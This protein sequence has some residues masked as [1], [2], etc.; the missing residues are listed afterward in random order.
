MVL[1]TED[2]YRI[3]QKLSGV[4]LEK[5][6]SDRRKAVKDAKHAASRTIV[7]NWNNTIE[8]NGARLLPFQSYIQ[9]SKSGA[10]L[11]LNN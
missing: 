9:Y 7:K 6:A 11:T 4:D 2:W 10:K 3:R 1:S 8:V 5:Q